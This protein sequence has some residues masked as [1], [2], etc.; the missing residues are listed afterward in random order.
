MRIFVGLFHG[1]VWFPSARYY[2]LGYYDG[3][4]GNRPD[5]ALEWS[6]HYDYGH[7][8]GSSGRD[9][10]KY[11]WNPKESPLVWLLVVGYVVT[12]IILK[13]EGQNG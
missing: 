3:K 11:Q 10:V 1:L 9:A 13:L 8:D 4:R 5:P 6:Q 7:Q 12:A 2:R